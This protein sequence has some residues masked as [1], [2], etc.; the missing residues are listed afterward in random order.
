MFFFNVSLSVSLAE[1]PE[2]SSSLSRLRGVPGPGVEAADVRPAL[3][4]P[5]MP[6][7]VSKC[8]KIV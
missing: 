6:V 5:R 7:H 2:K 3:I 8:S 4:G 1:S